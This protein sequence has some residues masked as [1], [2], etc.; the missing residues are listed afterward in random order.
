[1]TMKIPKHIMS[2][3]KPQGIQHSPVKRLCR[4]LKGPG[5]FICGLCGRKYSNAADAWKCLTSN[6]L[7][8]NSL[9]V[10]ATKNNTQTFLC[11]LCGKNYTNQSDTAHC[12]LRDLRVSRFPQSL[13]K[14]LYSLC[15]KLAEGNEKT[16]RDGMVTR[17]AVLGNAPRNQKLFKAPPPKTV[18]EPTPSLPAIDNETEHHADLESDMMMAQEPSEDAN[19]NEAESSSGESSAASSGEPVDHEADLKPKSDEESKPILYRKPD[20]KPFIRENAQYRC[21]V[22]NEKFFTKMEVE[23]HFE[24]HPLMDTV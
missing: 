19:H 13:G 4:V 20:Q 10:I 6:A 22:C 5:C 8:I 1:M 14:H 3:L 7:G 15:S 2:F 18:A 9:P 21:S 23:T 16:R 11:L 12:M 24:E 17:S